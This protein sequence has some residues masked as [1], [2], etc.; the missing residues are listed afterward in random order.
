MS[1]ESVNESAITSVVDGLVDF[2]IH[3]APS[4]VPRHSADP[5]TLA[6]ARSVGVRTF[7]LKAHEGSSADRAQLLGPE[8]VGG[9][10][11]NSTVG[12]ANPDAVEVAARLGARV[13]WLPTI[14]SPAHKAN[15]ARPE[16]QAHAGV[17]FRAVP[18]VEDGALRP[19][20]NE[21]LDVVA[22][23]AMVLCSGHVT[24]DE[25]VIVLS[26]ARRA[27]CR[28][29]RRQP[30]RSRLPRLARRARLAAA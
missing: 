22:R 24:I 7:V 20:W 26:E 4:I 13:V 9:V 25:A 2:H 23:H 27:R 15:D 16:L 5:E 18:V 30:S 12:G 19:E 17:S 14:S 8:V 11:L 1:A 21:V 29:A 10:V 28:A 3:S 6:A